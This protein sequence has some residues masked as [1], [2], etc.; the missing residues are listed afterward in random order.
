MGFLCVGNSSSPTRPVLSYW[1]KP[2]RRLT[3]PRALRA[4]I[5]RDGE[6]VQT[7]TGPRAHPGLRDE[8]SNRAF[9]VRTLEMTAAL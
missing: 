2:A 9:I 8:L 1:R 5:D 4:A 7:R 3:G 6:V